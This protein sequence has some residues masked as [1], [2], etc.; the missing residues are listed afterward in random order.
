MQ[1]ENSASVE[2]EFLLP[3][4]ATIKENIP[5]IYEPEA[6]Q[7]S[8]PLNPNIESFYFSGEHFDNEQQQTSSLPSQNDDQQQKQTP[9]DE[10]H[11]KNIQDHLVTDENENFENASSHIQI[12]FEPTQITQ[13]AETDIQLHPE[14]IP[15]EDKSTADADS[16]EQLS[17]AVNK[18]NITTIEEN[19]EHSNETHV[20]IQ[21]EEKANIS[22]EEQHVQQETFASDEELFHQ[23][24]KII[25]TDTV[26]DEPL[27]EEKEENMNE[28]TT[29]TIITETTTQLE[30]DMQPDEQ[31]EAILES[32]TETNA[33]YE[34][35]QFFNPTKN[36]TD[37]A[38]VTD[39][40]N[41]SEQSYAKNEQH[42]QDNNAKMTNIP[43]STLVGITETVVDDQMIAESNQSSIDAVEIDLNEVTVSTVIQTETTTSNADEANEEFTTENVLDMNNQLTTSILETAK[44]LASELHEKISPTNL[45]ETNVNN[46]HENATEYLPVEAET[47]KFTSA[48]NY[49]KIADELTTDDAIFTKY[50][51]PQ[52]NIEQFEEQ[53]EQSTAVLWTDAAVETK[54]TDFNEYPE[55]LTTMTTE[56][57]I[58][59]KGDSDDDGIAFKT[60][61]QINLPTIVDTEVETTTQSAV[62]DS[63][64]QFETTPFIEPF[65]N[66]HSTKYITAE[67][68]DVPESVDEHNFQLTT[69]IIAISTE[70]QSTTSAVEEFDTE[71]TTDAVMI[72]TKAENADRIQWNLAIGNIEWDDALTD[73]SSWQ[74]RKVSNEIQSGLFNILNT[75]IPEKV[76]EIKVTN[77][78]PE[79]LNIQGDA[80]FINR[81]EPISSLL[82]KFIANLKRNGNQIG[83]YSV[84]PM[85]IAFNGEKLSSELRQTMSE[86]KEPEEKPLLPTYVIVIIACVLA[87][88]ALLTLAVLVKRY[89]SRS[90]SEVFNKSIKNGNAVKAWVVNRATFLP[91]FKWHFLYLLAC[92]IAV[93]LMASPLMLLKNFMLHKMLI[94]YGCFTILLLSGHAHPST[95][96]KHNNIETFQVSR[97]L[98]TVGHAKIDDT[99]ITNEHDLT[100]TAVSAHDQLHAA[101]KQASAIKNDQPIGGQT[102]WM[103][104]KEDLVK[105][106][107]DKYSIAA[108]ALNQINQQRHTTP[109]SK[110]EMIELGET[111]EA[112]LNNLLQNE[113]AQIL[114]ESTENGKALMQNLANQFLHAYNTVVGNR[115]LSFSENF[116][117]SNIANQLLNMQPE[118]ETFRSQ[119]GA[120]HTEQLAPTESHNERSNIAKQHLAQEIN[121]PTTT[122]IP[123]FNQVTVNSVLKLETAQSVHE[124]QDNKSNNNENKKIIEDSP[125]LH[126]ILQQLDEQRKTENI[127]NEHQVPNDNEQSEEDNKDSVSN[128][129]E[130]TA[131]PTVQS[132]IFN[133]D[134][135]TEDKHS[136]PSQPEISEISLAEIKIPF[137]ALPTAVHIKFGNEDSTS[138]NSDYD[139]SI[140]NTSTTNKPEKT[141]H[142]ENSQNPVSVQE[143]I[144]PLEPAIKGPENKMQMENSASVE[145]EFL[146]PLNATIKENIPSIY[147]P[148]AEQKS[149][150]LNPNIESFY[151][152]GEHFDNEQQQTSSLPS[153]ND[154]QQQK[155]TPID[156]NHFKNI[157]DHLVTDENE[158]F[159]NASS[160]IQIPFEPTQITQ[161]AETD[162]QLHPESIPTEDKSTADA[163][164]EE[165]LSVAVNKQNITTIEENYEHSNETHVEIQ[166]EEKAN[167]SNEEQ[168]VQQETFASDEELFHQQP[169]II[170][171]DTVDDEP[172]QEEK[173][174]NMNEQTTTTIITE[175]TTQLE[176]DMQPDEQ[177]EA[178]LESNTETNAAY[179]SEQFFNPTKNETDTAVVTDVTNISEQSYAKNE[180][181]IQDNNAKM[182]N[183]PE[184]T[185]VGITETV[186]DDQMIAE[187]NQ[188]SIDA[189]E[190]D[191]NEVT[192][193]TVIQTETTTSNA[194]E[195]NEEFTT[196]NVLDMNNQLTTSILE[197][198][199]ELASELHEKI[200]PTN[201]PETNVNNIH[202]NATEYLPVEAETTKFTSA[203][204]YEKIADELTT[205]DAIF[206]KYISPQVNI[207]QF[208]EQPEQ[209]T[210][211][212]WTDAAVETKITD[213][214]EYPEILTTMTT[215]SQIIFKGDSDD[216]GIAFKT[217]EQ[218]N[219]PTIVDTEVETTTQSA[220]EDSFMQFETTPF[221]EPFQ[222]VHS[223]KYITA[224]IT[225]VPESVDEHNFQLTTE[226][227]AIST[228]KQSTTSAVEEFDT[229]FTTDAVMITTK[230]ENADRIQWNL[231]IG[232]IEWDDALTDKS[233]WQFRKVSNE[234][235]SGLF[236]ILNTIIPE[237][238]SEIKVTNIHPEHLNIQGDAVFINRT[239]PISSLL[240][241]FIANLK[242]NGN[243]IGE[244]SVDPM[245]IAFNGE[246]LSSELRQT[247]SEFK[248]PEEKPLLPTYVIVIIACVLAIAALLTLAVLVKRYRSRSGSEVF[249]K[250]IKNGNAVKAWAAHATPTMQYAQRSSFDHSNLYEMK[251]ASGP[252]PSHINYGFQNDVKANGIKNGQ[253]QIELVLQDTADSPK[254]CR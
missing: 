225:D 128:S 189:V 226:I 176:N 97:D 129:N 200:S 70:K 57:Q 12:P 118:L 122:T 113:T 109:L 163:D 29:T 96:N 140:Q 104:S 74:F 237:K 236:N 49:E 180:Q 53:P 144:P 202:E 229:E 132:T 190:I 188:S 254:Y 224:E 75:I 9:I 10:N 239:E 23:Q 186:V 168:H 191:L 134:I 102:N 214:N 61:E 164:S 155:Q 246:K 206:T 248:E 94:I 117:S 35:E 152:S 78:H 7:K 149:H 165:Q 107:F 84:D 31:T 67:I 14:S 123:Q 138:L 59:F 38:V 161:N 178:I 183:I 65:Q 195:A 171:T 3:L 249:N 232:N 2:G 55:I 181:H 90:G 111:F 17:V 40:T 79:H 54:I 52:V 5:S 222:N 131:E 86:F 21:P 143:Q 228:E 167:I 235:Q 110:E 4:N 174:E 170:Q 99:K 100:K 133:V 215:E 203:E 39:V 150:P 205:D 153:Q 185:L 201:L 16:E 213:F 173:E 218:I 221:I 244:Y 15:T 172:L 245:T 106:L 115:P 30:N 151:F 27:Q 34:S 154:D 139:E 233:S 48:E 91:S 182:T 20:E 204:N 175:T 169:K 193:S 199:K 211:V 1:M 18:Q 103:N 125:N 209:S 8:H 216:D 227:I 194:D 63:F 85:T 220:V 60:T 89:R 42:I 101:A 162:I 37:T 93:S 230:A 68:T 71:F 247:M 119:N 241:K 166:P 66:V 137:T 108:D 32:N 98:H 251:E 146:L 69:E 120:K 212:L 56:S 250:S 11:F 130:T 44:E 58:I 179:E 26:D 198:A 77:I 121:E 159:E 234:I 114:H 92:A 160:H 207:E 62:E 76:S 47:T 80:V 28:Q 208:E 252:F 136:N 50:I 51:S 6:E 145:G 223:T 148:E 41:I 135:K 240:E 142:D 73:K 45:P 83:E 243:Q 156:E 197:T 187:S 105:L 19:Y 24:P 210:A 81:T 127:H 88:A 141:Q 231:A 184:S 82:E 253:R 219:L 177:T 22:N 64:M 43:E 242:R 116:I 147:E 192:V 157:Q 158:N 95:I 124:H 112:T 196:E 238:V 87:I 13:N 33:A 25:Q 46:I 126:E 72:T 36:E 217:T